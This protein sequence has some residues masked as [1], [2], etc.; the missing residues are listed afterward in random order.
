MKRWARWI[1]PA[2][3]FLAAI[4]IIWFLH[5]FVEVDVSMSYINWDTSVQIFSDGTEEPFSYEAYSTDT[6]L[7]GT[8]R[9]TGTLPENLPAGNLLLEITGLDVAL[10]LDGE[11]LCHAQAFPAEGTWSMSQ[12]TVPLPENASGELILT[13][14]I[15]D[16]TQ[17]MF[18]PLLRFLPEDLNMVQDTAFAN[19]AAFPAGAAALA[20]LLVFGI[21]LLGVSQ[22]S[23]DFSLIPL[24]FATFGLIVSQIIPMEGYYFLPQ[25]A[26]RVLGGQA[27]PFLVVLLLLVYLAM[28]RRRR[29]WKYL[30]TAAAW[31]AGALLVCFLVSLVKDG[32]LSRYINDALLPEL[33]SGYYDGFL[34]WV[35][36]WL[37]F[38]CAMISAYG[39]MQNLAGHLANEQNLRMKNRMVTESYHA[40]EE[41]AL[42]DAERRHEYRHQLTALQCQYE[43]RDYEGVGRLLQQFLAHPK[44]QVSFTGNTAINTILQGAAAKA[45]RQGIPFTAS[46]HVPDSLNIP[47]TDLCALLM[48]MLDNALEAAQDPAHSVTPYIRIHIKAAGLYLAIKCENSFSGEIREDKHGKLLTTKA[49][50]AAH[51]FGI[52]QMERVA[53]KYHS[54]LKISYTD[55]GNFTVETALR[56]PG[57]AQPEA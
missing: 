20:L 27:I 46:V 31:S 40:L 13:C 48:N 52:P 57:G 23:P 7:S 41:W 14:E 24:L 11:T 45:D 30:I 22:K 53:E 37:A 38:V 39:V 1:F 21:F 54:L 19:R 44:F 33:R 2:L 9:F 56:I 32:Y 17:A 35:S 28:N 25:A 26:V 18:P 6:S 3:F 4:A 36:L 12:V 49:D 16:G 10:A 50:S 43:N 15:L 42:Q 47:D 51:G 8:Y 29:F 55:T 5:L 34:Y